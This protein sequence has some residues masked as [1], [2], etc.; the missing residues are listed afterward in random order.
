MILAWLRIAKDAGRLLGYGQRIDRFGD[1]AR[2]E[3]NLG[4][5][6]VIDQGFAGCTRSAPRRVLGTLAFGIIVTT[7]ISCIIVPEVGVA[8]AV[9]ADASLSLPSAAATIVAA[10]VESTERGEGS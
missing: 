10:L 4:S 9:V 8:R 7:A 5:F 6:V 3:H 1:R 2:I